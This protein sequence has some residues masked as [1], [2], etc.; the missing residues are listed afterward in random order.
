MKFKS[1]LATL[2]LLI[3]CCCSK[4]ETEPAP[5]V[6]ASYQGTVS[7]DYM[8][9]TFDNEDVEVNYEPSADGKTADIIINKIKFVPQMPVTIDV[10][11]PRV[12][13]TMSDGKALLYCDNVIPFAL[14]GEYPR[15]PVTGLTGTVDGDILSFSLNFGDYPTRFSGVKKQ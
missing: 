11:I 5:P 1:I 12:S 6:Q 4:E 14:G 7:V 3:A 13:V 15:Y 9:S 10:T 8:G 2:L